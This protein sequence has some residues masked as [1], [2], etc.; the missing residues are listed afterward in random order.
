MFRTYQEL[1]ERF[2]MSIRHPDK[3]AKNKNKQIDDDFNFTV[4][5]S[6]ENFLGV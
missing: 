5:G 3:K 4:E 2:M 1:I 6:I